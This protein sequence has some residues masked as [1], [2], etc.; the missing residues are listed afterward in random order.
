MRP[1]R[2]IVVD[3]GSTDGTADSVA[4]WLQ[5]ARPG[6]DALLIRQPQN[7]GA[8]AALNRGLAMVRDC[9]YLATLDSDDVW[10][11]DFV[12]RAC[13][14]L[15]ER[16]E[17]VAATCDQLHVFDDS[18]AT[19]YFDACGIEPNGARRLFHDGN[20]I[21]S[22]TML[23]T[24]DIMELGG[25]NERLQTGYDTELFLSLSLRGPWLHVPGAPAIIRRP[26]KHRHGES[27]HLSSK[28]VDNQ[29][30]WAQIYDDFI[31]Q[32]EGWRTVPR[33]LYTRKLADRWNCAGHQLMRAGRIAEARR[34]FRRSFRWRPW[35][36]S[37]WSQLLKTYAPWEIR[38]RN[39]EAQKDSS[40]NVGHSSS[41]LRHFFRSSLRRVI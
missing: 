9:R 15:I 32:K 22:T 37:V 14:A 41:V 29:R 27:A 21:I 23:S 28:F 13:G 36:S 19:E 26:P 11:L 10:P 40:T 20:G 7:G 4:E 24:R 35:R 34:C 39:D 18:Q 8:P 6:F 2:L 31:E 16:P 33:L 1:R 30:R 25:F 38:N 17:A 3:D 5:A 12:E